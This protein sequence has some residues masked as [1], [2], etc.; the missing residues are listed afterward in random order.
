M[1][2]IWSMRQAP[3]QR[4]G[5]RLQKKDVTKPQI[6]NLSVFRGHHTTEDIFNT[7]PQP[8]STTDIQRWYK[9]RDVQRIE[10]S[11]G[12]IRGSLFIPPGENT[13]FCL[14]IKP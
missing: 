4:D 8:L 13:T 10:L 5:L 14:L 7:S 11:D 12:L 3:G 1:G 9:A 2:L 6:V